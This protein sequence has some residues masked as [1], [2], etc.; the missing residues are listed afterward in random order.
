MVDI[1]RVG[2]HRLGPLNCPKCGLDITRVSGM[3]RG[4]PA[5][6]YRMT[7]TGLMRVMVCARCETAIAH[8]DHKLMVVDAVVEAWLP[9]EAKAM[10]VETRN[11]LRLHKALGIIT[12]PPMK[13]GG[14]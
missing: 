2:P 9:P 5:A 10:L 6:E 3:K 8:W 12:V 11:E 7:D 13:E 14:E 4:K 1:H